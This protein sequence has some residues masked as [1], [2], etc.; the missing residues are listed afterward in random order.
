MDRWRFL[1]KKS[2][3]FYSIFQNTTCLDFC[4]SLSLRLPDFGL[5]LPSQIKTDHVLY[6]CVS[7]TNSKL[8]LMALKSCFW[9]HPLLWL[10]FLLFAHMHPVHKA[11]VTMNNLL[12]M[13]CSFFSCLCMCSFC[14]WIF[15]LPLISLSTPFNSSLYEFFLE[16]PVS[17]WQEIAH[18]KG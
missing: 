11:Y 17:V 5:I 4:S 16:S 3:H 18:S 2:H 8:P 13:P 9:P 6:L 14:N 12:S 10:S 15:F 1:I 7:K